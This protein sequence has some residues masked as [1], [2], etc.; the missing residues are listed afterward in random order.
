M[1]NWG[2]VTYRENSLLFDPQSSSS[3]NKERVVTVIA[4]ELAHQV[5]SPQ[6]REGREGIRGLWEQMAQF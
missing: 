4:H 1:E 3:T 6:H 2:L 5:A